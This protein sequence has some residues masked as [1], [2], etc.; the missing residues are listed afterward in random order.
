M[1]L[2]PILGGWV[3]SYDLETIQRNLNSALNKL[4]EFDSFLLKNSANERSITHKLAEYL[5]SEFD[6]WNVDCEYNKINENQNIEPKKIR[7]ENEEVSIYDTDAKTVFPDIIVHQRHGKENLLVIEAKKFRNNSN[8]DLDHLKLCKFTSKK[9]DFKY[10]YGFH[11]T[12][13]TGK[14]RYKEFP[15]M[16]LYKDGKIIQKGGAVNEL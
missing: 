1:R 16:I 15:T 7:L 6:D 9:H 3:M 13:F 2:R 12:F 8:I 11:I 10:E 5:Q 14:T 4:L